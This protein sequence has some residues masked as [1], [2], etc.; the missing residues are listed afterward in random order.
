MDFV[1]GNKFLDWKGDLLVGF[2]KFNYVEL[3]KLNG[4][5]IIGCEKIVEDIGCVWNVKMGFDGYIYIVLEG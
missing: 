2:L 1:I 4:D 5:K 3:V